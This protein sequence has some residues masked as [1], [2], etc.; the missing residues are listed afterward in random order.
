MAS[1]ISTKSDAVNCPTT[2]GVESDA[3]LVWITLRN[4]SVRGFHNIH[5]AAERCGL[6]VIHLPH[7]FDDPRG[8]AAAGVAVAAVA[9]GDGPPHPSELDVISRL[10]EMGISVIAYADGVNS[11]PIGMRCRVL[12]AGAKQ[13]LD[14]SASTFEALFSATLG[15]EATTVRRRHVE[16]KELRALARRHGIFGDSSAMLDVIRLVV[17]FSKLSNLPVL[18]T[19]ESGTGKEL[20]ASAIQALDP[21]R[22]GLPFVSVNCAAIATSL[23]ESELFGNVKGAFTGATS[24]RRGYFLAA[25]NG[26][27]FLDEIGELNLDLQ[28]K[29][30]RV[31]EEKQ[32]WQVGA[33]KP[34]PVDVRVIAASNRDIPTLIKAHLFREDL[35]YRLNILAV[36]IAPLRERPEDLRSLAE[37]FLE[38]AASMVEGASQTLDRELIEALALLP[39]YGNAREL[40]NLILAAVAAKPVGGA[41]GLSDLPPSL[42]REL[43]RA[44]AAAGPHF[45]ADQSSPGADQAAKI[46]FPMRIAQQYGWKLN[47]CL[48]HLEREIL[49]AAMQQVHYN[50]SRAARLLGLTPRSIYNKLRKYHLS[51][52]EI[53]LS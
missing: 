3:A 21:K 9:F 40:R 24:P 38:T 11:W 50:Q 1:G 46:G 14:A 45:A 10:H 22:C 43:S 28:A 36:G 35:F 17:R 16:R 51:G 27:L 30:L 41:I 39:L 7:K 19:G 42:W 18:I 44:E 2:N 52:R 6:R 20:V 48:D 26:T 31:L 23:A 4:A 5:A 47:A 53:P 29:L 37:H 15:T 32:V 49:E 8:S 34:L 12:L 13:L 25:D 33:D